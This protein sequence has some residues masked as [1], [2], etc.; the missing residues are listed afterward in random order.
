MRGLVVSSDTSF[1]LSRLS[2]FFFL[3]FQ[4]SA[5]DITKGFIPSE[6]S[7]SWNETPFNLLGIC[8]A[9]ITNKH[10]LE[11]S[12]VRG[13]DFGQVGPLRAGR[14]QSAQLTN[15]VRQNHN[16]HPA[17]AMS[18]PQA[19]GPV[20]K[21]RYIV[22]DSCSSGTDCTPCLFLFLCL[23]TPWNDTVATLQ[24]RVSI[25]DRM[26][27]FLS[28][29]LLGVPKSQGEKTQPIDSSVCGPRRCELLRIGQNVDTVHCRSS[30]D[31]RGAF[32][33]VLVRVSHRSC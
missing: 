23:T 11:S 15:Q 12:S 16:Q 32:H 27:F 28:P 1:C 19:R 29:Q 25:C 5:H 18:S 3:I 7:A 8:W 31:H 17:D 24:L 22:T 20:G 2:V 9:Q 4:E 21:Q 30:T 33:S 26:L 13:G 10:F 14:R 6:T